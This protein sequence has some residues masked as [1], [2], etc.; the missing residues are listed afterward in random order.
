MKL[1]ILSNNPSRASFRQRIGIYLDTLQ[2]NGINCEVA[3]L[4]ATEWARLKLF[5]SAADFDAAYLHKK[6]LNLLDAFCLKKYTKKII[7]DFDDAVMY[8]EVEPEQISRK[9]LNS[10]ERTIGLASLVIAGNSYLAKQALLFNSNV[11]VLPTG[12]DVKA[13]DGQKTHPDDRVRLVWI[14]SKSTLEY[15]ETIR[16]VLEQ[17][18]KQFKNVSLRIISDKF[19]D[20][21]NMD[22]EKRNWSIQT[23]YADLTG[24]DIGL[25][26]LP[27]N[28]FTQGK[29]GFKILQ[30][31]AAGLPVITSPVGVNAQFVE[32]GKSG[33]HAQSNQQWIDAITRLVENSSIRIQMGQ[34]GKVF[35]Q[36]FDYTIIGRQLVKLLKEA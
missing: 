21:E 33:F 18:G 2:S 29:C 32:N 5:R 23:Q 24:S 15:L 28:H 17:T 9:R 34:A 26:P 19:I 25:A 10:F 11:V 35:V 31:Q 13:Y 12:L 7:Y 14:G 1:L 27:D 3:K 22:V 6:R 36:K 16:P 8:D 4:P 30:Y 20:L